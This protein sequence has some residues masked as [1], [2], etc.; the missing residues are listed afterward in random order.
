MKAKTT[1]A[2]RKPAPKHQRLK[3]ALIPVLMLVLAYVL[4]AP[5]EIPVSDE[6][7]IDKVLGRSPA[8]GMVSPAQ[9]AASGAAQANRPADAQ[10]WPEASLE[11]LAT[12]NPFQSLVSQSA[13][14]TDH[15]FVATNAP[16]LIKDVDHLAN[17]ASELERRPVNFIFR[18]SKQNVIMLGDEVLEKGTHLS[19]A[20]QLQ[21][22]DDHTLLLKL[23]P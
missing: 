9:P 21:D 4:F 19:P 13:E 12:S 23:H 18:S 22:I 10:A 1:T 6:V 11:F 17:V 2:A 3:I 8:A 7:P 20:V 15:R 16:A 5:A 14:S